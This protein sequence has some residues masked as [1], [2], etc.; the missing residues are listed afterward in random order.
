MKDGFVQSH[1]HT[2]THTYIYMHLQIERSK[3]GRESH[4]LK[5]KELEKVVKDRQTK[6]ARRVFDRAGY[7]T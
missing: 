5:T 2:H 7:C 1:T 4:T 6:R 3:A